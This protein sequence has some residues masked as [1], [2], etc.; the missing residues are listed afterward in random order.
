[1]TQTCFGHLIFEH[2]NLFRISDFV[3]RIYE[4]LPLVATGKSDAGMGCPVT[5]PAALL[6]EQVIL[7]RRRRTRLW[8][9]QAQDERRGSHRNDGVSYTLAVAGMS[10]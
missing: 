1:M 2:L 8:R 9:G 5:G 10:G 7:L 3:L 6:S 4:W